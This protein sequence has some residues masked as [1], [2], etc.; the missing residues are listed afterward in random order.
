[1]IRVRWRVGPHAEGLVPERGDKW[2]RGRGEFD[3]LAAVVVV[4]LLLIHLFV[5]LLWCQRCQLRTRTR[6][7]ALSGSQGELAARRPKP[8]QAA[9]CMLLFSSAAAIVQAEPRQNAILMAPPK[10]ACK[11]G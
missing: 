1:M 3:E 9:A 11:F 10:L 2:L 8:G 6:T 7:R 5:S 4:L